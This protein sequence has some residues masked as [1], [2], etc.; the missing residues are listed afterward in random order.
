M[1]LNVPKPEFNDCDGGGFLPGGFT[2]LIYR[3][4]GYRIICPW[5]NFI[6]SLFIPEFPDNIL[7]DYVHSLLFCGNGNLSFVIDHYVFKN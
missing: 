4:H 6:I 7:S 3:Y 1:I 5:G 2:G